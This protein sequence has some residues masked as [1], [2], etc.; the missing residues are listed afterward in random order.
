[1]VCNSFKGQGGF[2]ECV[3]AHEFHRS[4]F[5]VASPHDETYGYALQFI[6]CKFETGTFVVRVVIFHAYALGFQFCGE[7]LETFVECSSVFVSF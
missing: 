3:A 5:E 2:L 1:M 6:V 7:C 4:V